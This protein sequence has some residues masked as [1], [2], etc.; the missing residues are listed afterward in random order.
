MTPYPI[1]HALGIIS[2]IRRR[3]LGLDIV[4]LTM[5]K[6]KKKS[7]RAFSRKSRVKFQG[8]KIQQKQGFLNVIAN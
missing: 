6:F 7:I 8:V 3:N 1:L 5:A 2:K 4:V